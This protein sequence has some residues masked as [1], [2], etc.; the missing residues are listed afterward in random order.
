VLEALQP[1]LA[2]AHVL[3]G[4]DRREVGTTI[5]QFGD[6]LL[7]VGLAEIAAGFGP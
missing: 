5:E 6:E 7:V 4:P 3:P 2:T 1:L